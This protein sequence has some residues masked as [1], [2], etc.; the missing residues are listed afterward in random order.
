MTTLVFQSPQAPWI[1]E[2]KD[3]AKCRHPLPQEMNPS[4]FLTWRLLL[5]QAGTNSALN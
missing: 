1:A 3:A 4:V 2:E 5:D